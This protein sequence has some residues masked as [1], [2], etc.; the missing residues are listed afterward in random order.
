VQIRQLDTRVF[1][2]AD[3]GTATTADDLPF[4][5]LPQ[6]CTAALATQVTTYADPAASIASLTLNLAGACVLF[7][8]GFE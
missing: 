2:S 1:G 3:Q 5:R 4:Q 7:S 8:N 6:G